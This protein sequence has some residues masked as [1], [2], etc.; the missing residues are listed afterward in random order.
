M[1]EL[2]VSLVKRLYLLSPISSTGFSDRIESLIWY[3]R[4]ARWTKRNPAPVSPTKEDFYESLVVSEGLDEPIEY[5]EFGV[6]EG[7]SIK[8]WLS[9]VGHRDALFFG[10]DSFEGLPEAWADVGEGHFDTGGQPPAP[11]LERCAYIK[12]YFQ[13]TVPGFVRNVLSDRRHV[14]HLDADLYSSTLLVLTQ[15]GPYLRP[16]DVLIFDEFLA[17]ND[18]FRALQN[19]LAALP[20]EYRVLGRTVKGN[21]VAIGITAVPPRSSWEGNQ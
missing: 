19:F 17:W 12:G 10:C 4:F 2:F 21:Q 13:C 16:N 1:R 20:L 14:I 11:E 9:R 15:L 3:G 8:W 6:F 7:Y 5:L 18:E